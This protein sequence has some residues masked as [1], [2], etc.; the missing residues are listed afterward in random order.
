VFST[1]GFVLKVPVLGFRKM[2]ATS[3]LIPPTTWTALLPAISIAP[4]NENNVCL[5]K[6]W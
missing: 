4:K 6:L 5:A 1:P 3:P 2:V